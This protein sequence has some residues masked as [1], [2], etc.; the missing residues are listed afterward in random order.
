MS[1]GKNRKD[2]PLQVDPIQQQEFFIS[3]K[4]GNLAKVKQMVKDR[5]VD[6]NAKDPDDPKGATAIIIASEL[7]YIQIVEILMK[8]KPR[9]A[10]VNAETITGRRAIW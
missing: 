7:G 5:V 9:H 1:K 8:A 4:S 3:V 2:K 6:V 10:D